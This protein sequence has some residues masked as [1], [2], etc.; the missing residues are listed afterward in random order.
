MTHA[1]LLD[2]TDPTIEEALYAFKRITR[3]YALFHVTFFSLAL[4]QLLALLLFFSSLV[5]STALAFLLAALL[6]T[7]FS[8]FVLL[9]YLQAKKPQQL[10]N[11]KEN[12]LCCWPAMQPLEQR[13]LLRSV[14]QEFLSQLHRQE[15]RYYRGPKAFETLSLL[16]RKFSVWAH[17]KDVYLMKEILAFTLLQLE[18]EE[19][20]LRPLDLN[21]HA[22]LA[23]A[24]QM[25]AKLYIDPRQEEPDVEHLFVSPEYKAPAM[26]HKFQDATSRAIEELKILDAYSPENPWVQLRLAELHHDLGHIEEETHAYETLL[27]I[28][29][30]DPEWLLKLGI[31]YF[32]QG[33]SAKGLQL[34]AKLKEI[35]PP[36]AGEL[37][38]HYASGSLP[39]GAGE[40]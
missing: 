17:W 26:R 3:N 2:T 9:F 36:R 13:D 4:L 12:F 33:Q 32:L 30:D 28:S 16:L 38:T 7:A 31:L 24:Y 8:Y 19:V 10:T 37:I 5:Q 11:L 27:K 23:T 34:Y 35:D 6:F 39:E 1:A 14:L 15:Y 18:I 22:H 25:L 20:K 21:A 40:F 29:P